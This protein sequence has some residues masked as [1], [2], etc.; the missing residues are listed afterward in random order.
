LEEK[1]I[2]YCRIDC[3]VVSCDIVE[4]AG[5]VEWRDIGW[6]EEEEEDDPDGRA[7]CRPRIENLHFNKETYFD[8]VEKYR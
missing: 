1:G 3:G 8:C 2:T 4:H 6:E 5:S 7:V